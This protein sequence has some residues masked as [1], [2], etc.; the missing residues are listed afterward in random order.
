MAKKKKDMSWLLDDQDEN[1][2]EVVDANGNTLQAGDT[3]VATKDLKVKGSADI[4]R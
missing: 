2:L 3:V 1:T 4:K